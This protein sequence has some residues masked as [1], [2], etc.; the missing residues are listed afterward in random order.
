M[1][2]RLSAR[3][4]MSLDGSLPRRDRKHGAYQQY[5]PDLLSERPLLVPGGVSEKARQAERAVRGLSTGPGAAGLEGLTRFLL[6]SEAI[7]SSLIEGIAP[8][9]QQVAMAELS[10]D[11]PVRGFSDSARLV[12]NNIT[13]LRTAAQDLVTADAVRV[14]DVAG[15]QAALLPEERHHGLRVVQ[16]WIGGSSWHPLDAEFVPPPPDLVGPLMDDL[17]SYLNGAVHAPLVQAAVVHAHFETVHPFTDGNGRVGRA[18]IHTV[19]RRRGLTP[20]AVLPVS[21]ILAT[22]SGAYADGLTAY[23]YDGAADSPPAHEGVARWLDLFLDA[24]LAAAAQ[25]QTFAN[26]VLRLQHQWE[27]QVTAHRTRQGVRPVPRADSATARLL[28]VLPDAPILTV[29]TAQRLLGVSAP[30]GR[31]GLDE[32]AEA[33]VL[34]RRSVERG[35]TGYV[36]SELFGVVTH[37]ERQLASTRWDTRLAPASR[38]VPARPAPDHDTQ[39]TP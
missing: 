34:A 32:L 4:A 2:H 22:L 36:A 1:A 8:S 3:W 27:E 16:N 15:L 30:A 14:E 13:V 38:P 5:V 9:P 10:Q 28:A 33:G 25:A 21:L 24:T 19:L 39:R 7:A 11:E 20:T 18:L 17:V 23:R 31:A 29:R 12:A 6:R 35:T 37:A 26:Q